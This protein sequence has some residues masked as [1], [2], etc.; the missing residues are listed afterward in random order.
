MQR[1]NGWLYP[2]PDLRGGDNRP[3]PGN[4]RV[5]ERFFEPGQSRQEERW[6]TTGIRALDQ[7]QNLAQQRQSNPRTAPTLRQDVLTDQVRQES[8]RMTDP[9][10]ASTL[11]NIIRNTDA[12]EEVRR[13][14][15][16][17]K[18]NRAR[19][20]PSEIAEAKNHALEIIEDY[21][22]MFFETRYGQ[23][24]NETR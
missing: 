24:S 10:L 16:V 23:Q 4:E 5:D 19:Y 14:I 6:N 22:N 17:L 1:R 13:S 18:H 21:T 15:E 2:K 8:R 20:T 7:V 3:N 9:T 12:P 11:E